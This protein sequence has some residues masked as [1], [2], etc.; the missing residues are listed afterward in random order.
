MIADG[1]GSGAVILVSFTGGISQG[2]SERV[3]AGAVSESLRG[4]SDRNLGTALYGGRL[5]VSG[6]AERFPA[7]ETVGT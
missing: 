7:R 1:S 5:S 4:P 2:A 3:L 6:D